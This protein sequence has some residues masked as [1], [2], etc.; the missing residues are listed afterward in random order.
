MPSAS[1][2]AALGYHFYHRGYFEAAHDYWSDA[3]ER[4]VDRTVVAEIQ[5][6]LGRMAAQRGRPGDAVGHFQQALAALPSDASAATRAAID[7]RSAMALAR[8]G[9]RDQALRQAYQ[10]VQTHKPSEPINSALR[11][12]LAALQID[13]GLYRLAVDTLTDAL[14]HL[15]TEQI[16]RYGYALQTN[17]GICLLETNRISDARASFLQ[18]LTLPTEST[19]HAING[20]AR[21]A[22]V[23]HRVDEMAVWGARAFAQMWDTLMSFE[24]EE[25]ARLAEVLGHMALS[26][27]DGRLAVRLFD[28]A[29][30]LYGRVGLWA[31][32]SALNAVLTAAEQLPDQQAKTGMAD[33]L[34]RFAVLLESMLA[35]ELVDSRAPALADVRH[36]MADRLAESLGWTQ[37]ERQHLAYVCRLADLGLSAVG[38]SDIHEAAGQA[39][40][41]LYERHPEL[42]VRLLDRLELPEAVVAGILDHHERWDGSGFPG[43]KSGAAIARAARIFAT[44]DMYARQTMAGQRHRDVLHHMQ[45]QA[46]GGLDPDCVAALLEEF[47]VEV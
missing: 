23:D 7:M 46:Q 14:E 3:L 34:R 9:D 15:G 2:L 13:N 18:A 22:I 43:G 35:Q 40:H 44:A 20:L 8:L 12:N 36:W 24:P 42:S 41:P 26:F 37:D 17:L 29:Q 27:D 28:R 32:W 38:I 11:I 25:L 5:D 19:I 16:P 30:A 33:E 45:G 31:E 21:I 1:A 10:V 4:G 6:G 39:D 47:T